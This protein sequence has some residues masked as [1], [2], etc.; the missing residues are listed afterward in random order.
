MNLTT[1]LPTFSPGE[2]SASGTQI[3]LESQSAGDSSP[4]RR[5]LEKA[6]GDFESIL[7]ASMWKS[8]KQSFGSS[9]SDGETDPAHGTLEDWGME[10][11]SSAV[12][13]AGG[14]GIGQLILKHLEPLV[15]EGEGSDSAHSSK[16][17]AD[18]ADIPREEAKRRWMR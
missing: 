9:E 15:S 7:L 12:G 6:A 16:G 4:E 3:S 1:S 2:I 14:L 17:L 10:I 13:R 8:M 11:M 18:S 5:K